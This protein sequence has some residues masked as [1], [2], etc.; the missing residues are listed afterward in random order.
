VPEHPRGAVIF[1]HGSDSSSHS[2]RNRDVATV[3]N[4]AGLA[5]LLF[6]LLTPA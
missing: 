3:L 6:D 5:T 1:V 4:R 2:P